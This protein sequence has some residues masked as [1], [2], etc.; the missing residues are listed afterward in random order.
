MFD[1]PRGIFDMILSS[2]LAT[3][4]VVIIVGALSIG[5]VPVTVVRELWEATKPGNVYLP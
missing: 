5:H 4:D 3:Y 1:K 2:V